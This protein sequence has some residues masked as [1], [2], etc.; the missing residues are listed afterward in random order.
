VVDAGGKEYQQYLNR[1]LAVVFSLG[2]NSALRR[3]RQK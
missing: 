2:Y 3:Q 1:R